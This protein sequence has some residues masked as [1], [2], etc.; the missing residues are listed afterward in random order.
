MACRQPQP[1]Q[2]EDFTKSFLRADLLHP[3]DSSMARCRARGYEKSSGNH[4]RSG[5][6]SSLAAENAIEG[7]TDALKASPK[8]LS[9][10]AWPCKNIVLEG[11]AHSIG[12]DAERF[13]CLGTPLHISVSHIG[14]RPLRW[15]LKG[16]EETCPTAMHDSGTDSEIPQDARAGHT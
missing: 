15:K 3:I 8:I 1:R 5:I 11:I 6:C 14:H 16:V 10:M 13:A 4:T 9:S 12:F 7:E 2:E